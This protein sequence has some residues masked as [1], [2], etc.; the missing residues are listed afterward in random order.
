MANIKKLDKFEQVYFYSDGLKISGQ[1]SPALN[2]KAREKKPSIIC[3][4]GY[5]GRKDVY[6]PSYVRE[7]NK[8]GYNTLDFFHRG[9]GDSEG[10]RLRNNPW[11]QVADAISALIYMQQR[12]EVDANRIG[13][14]GTSFG[15]SV[16]IQAAA[17]DTGFKC[18]VSVGSPANVGR[19]FKSK[20][21]Y[22]E[23]LDWEDEL[24]LDRIQRVLTGKSKR[25]T[26]GELVPS[27]RAER[28]AIQT[29]YKTAEGYPEGYP[30]ESYDLGTVFV[31]EKN[32]HKISPRASLFIHADRDT[33]VPLSEAESF[34]A[35]AREPKKLIVLP[36]ATHVDVYEPRNPATFKVVIKHMKEFFSENL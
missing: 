2:L 1:F 32:A 35:H 26:Y 14:Y 24:K 19:S 28:D 23:W 4:H 29:M 3:L 16:A 5:S 7:L 33:M 31:P 36:N 12:S 21:T 8:A 10:I 18:V 11:E 34:Y 30:M 6:M 27:G 15:G 25:V 9:F 22:G 13:L 20:R 17:Q